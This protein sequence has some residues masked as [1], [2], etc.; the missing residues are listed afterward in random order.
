LALAIIAMLG[1]APLFSRSHRRRFGGL[2][3]R[4]A[5][6]IAAGILYFLMLGTLQWVSDN[7][8]SG[9]YVNPTL[10]IIQTAIVALIV[11]LANLVRD[12]NL[13]RMEVLAGLAVL[14]A[15]Y[16]GFGLPSMSQVRSHVAIV[17]PV[18]RDVIAE[19]CTH[20]AG[21]YW[22]VWPIVY[23]ATLKLYESGD[24]RPVYGVTGRA[25][26]VLQTV[27]P[28]QMRVALL[29]SSDKEGEQ[30]LQ[31]YNLGPFKLSRRLPTITVLEASK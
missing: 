23:R 31:T 22:D 12:A 16:V 26:S 20:V 14:L 15:A 17:D 1:L 19:R 29:A 13:R 10:L 2:Y 3:L 25:G 6:L 9:R 27:P 28:S 24:P 5:L 8:Y 11:P 4:S 18:T 21:N 7:L 30:W